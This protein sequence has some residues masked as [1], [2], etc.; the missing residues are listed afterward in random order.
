MFLCVEIYVIFEVVDN[1]DCYVE[2]INLIKYKLLF[3]I[4]VMYIF[5]LYIFIIMIFLMII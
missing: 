5:N 1:V 4:N 2:Y 3:E